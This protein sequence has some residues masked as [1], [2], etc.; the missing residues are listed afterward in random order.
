MFFV[1]RANRH[2]ILFILL[3]SSEMLDALDSYLSLDF[4]DTL[5]SWFSYHSFEFLVGLSFSLPCALRLKSKSTNMAN[6]CLLPRDSWPPSHHN[7]DWF[8]LPSP[9]HLP[10]LLWSGN[11]HL[12]TGISFSKTLSQA[13]IVIITL[14]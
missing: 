4:R 12:L 3:C 5:C 10:F 2:L 1:D 13:A 14:Y 11:A 7:T 9:Q 8:P 6:L